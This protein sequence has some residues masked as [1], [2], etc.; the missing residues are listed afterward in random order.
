MNAQYLILLVFLLA[1]ANLPATGTY[2]E[3]DEFI[4]EVFEGDPPAPK[5]LWITKKLREPVKEIMGRSLGSL[6]VRYW[7]WDGR[8][9]LSAAIGGR[10][11]D[12]HPVAGGEC[13]DVGGGGCS[14]ERYDMHRPVECLVMRRGGMGE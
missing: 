10:G 11:E 2:Q 13:R 6:R 9:G 5:V 8:V 7:A 1:P 14:V 3:P 4:A 12:A